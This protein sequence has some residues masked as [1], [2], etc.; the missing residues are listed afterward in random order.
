[1]TIRSGFGF[2]DSGVVGVFGLLLTCSSSGSNIQ[3]GWDIYGVH[4]R[5]SSVTS[6]LIPTELRGMGVNLGSSQVIKHSYDSIEDFRYF[7]ITLF[8]YR[9]SVWPTDFVE[10]VSRYVKEA[11]QSLGYVETF[12]FTGDVSSCCNIDAN[13]HVRRHTSEKTYWH[14]FFHLWNEEKTKT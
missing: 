11:P 14:L 13:S 10:Q 3:V 8:R 7:N 5:S 12:G 1:M 9:K 6:C 2:D 4:F